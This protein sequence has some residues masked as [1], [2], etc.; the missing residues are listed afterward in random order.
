MLGT[1]VTSGD[2]ELLAE[3]SAK[4]RAVAEEGGGGVC[5]GDVGGEGRE[6]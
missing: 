4:Q 3:A 6:E 2:D 1:K 5:G